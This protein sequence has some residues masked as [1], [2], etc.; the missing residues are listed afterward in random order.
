MSEVQQTISPIDG[1]IYVE[2]HL[3]DRDDIDEAVQR[4]NQSLNDW[5]KL[6][7]NQRRQLCSQAVDIFCSL[8]ETIA[9]EITWQMGRPILQTADEVKGFAYRAKYM[10]N[11]AES[12]LQAVTPE[13]KLGVE[14]YIQ[15]VPV[16][17]V[18]I[19]APWNYPLLTAVNTLIP[20]LVAGNAVILKH[21]PQTPLCSE[22]IV[23]AFHLA[24]V[25]KDVIQYL[26]LSEA[27][28]NYLVKETSIHHV[29]FTGSVKGGGAIEKAAAG[30]FLGVGL[31]LGGKD[32]AYICEDADIE[33]AVNSIISGAYYNSGQSCCSIERLYVPEKLFDDV[34]ELSIQQINQY[35]FG[36]P[37]NIETNLG[38]LVCTRSADFVRQQINQAIAKGATPHIDT[39]RFE[40]NQTGTPYKAPQ[41]LSNV[42]HSMNLMTEES[43]G[44]VLGIQKVANDDEAVTL[45]N[46]SKYGL[47]ASIY[48]PDFHR[49]KKLGEKINTGSIYVNK[50]DFLDP[51]LAWTG[52][53]NSGHGCSLSILG[54]DSVTRP[55]SFYFNQGR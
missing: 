54:Y 26:H 1:S 37:D 12:A 49:A 50:C 16:G 43:F 52:V 33:T 38:P 4:A 35:Q 24:G 25:P 41:L 47:T 32:A 36:R 19:I 21:S 8:K 42:D 55:K 34:L 51:A 53:K 10:L 29:A 15:K 6:S 30:R 3:A 45:I 46:D 7:I 39:S 13:E 40:F 22:R 5:Q 11:I 20:A 27:G 48:T 18:A 14:R 2:R 44:P 28:V 9:E 23:E 31:E 17:V